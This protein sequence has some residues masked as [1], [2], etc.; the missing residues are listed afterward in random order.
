MDCLILKLTLSRLGSA[1]GGCRRTP[2]DWTCLNSAIAEDDGVEVMRLYKEENAE[3][4]ILDYRQR[5]PCIMAV[6]M[7]SMEALKAL[8]ICGG[9]TS[10]RGIMFMNALDM[11]VFSGNKEAVHICLNSGNHSS[12]E[13]CRD[14]SCINSF[15]LAA[16]TN[17]YEIMDI[18]CDHD[19]CVSCKHLGSPSPIEIACVMGNDKVLKVMLKYPSLFN[20]LAKTESMDYPMFVALKCHPF[21]LGH[22][23]CFKMLLQK[24]LLS[25]V[26][27]FDKRGDHAIQVALRLDRP[28]C[29]EELLST[30]KI[31][32]M[33]S[34]VT[35]ATL[36]P[37]VKSVGMDGWDRLFHWVKVDQNC[38]AILKKLMASRLNE[39]VYKNFLNWVSPIET[40]ACKNPTNVSCESTPK[41]ADVD[42]CD[43]PITRS[44]CLNLLKW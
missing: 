25:P 30:P 3:L 2:G 18:L 33:F 10:I 9:D 29:L 28:E 13:S 20:P 16:G 26:G 21:T 32:D 19:M 23:E 38:S 34:A 8:V 6:E 12:D 14:Q 17:Q 5:T 31:W 35:V 41:H 39:S 36:P 1:W 7:S 11:A 37:L 22:L 15:A 4:N 42:Q 44:K 27:L 24:A 43:G 40:S